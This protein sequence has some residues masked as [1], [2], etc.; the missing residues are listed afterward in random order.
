MGGFII[1][2]PVT[3]MLLSPVDG[4]CLKAES[5]ASTTQP[6]LST[7]VLVALRPRLPSESLSPRCPQDRY[8]GDSLLFACQHKRILLVGQSCY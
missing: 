6:L 7:E 5:P 4:T 2:Y 3:Y 8:R 1:Y